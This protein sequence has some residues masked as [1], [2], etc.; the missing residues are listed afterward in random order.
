M[1][2]LQDDVWKRRGVSLLWGGQSAFSV[3]TAAERG[4]DSP[5]LRPGREV[6]RRTTLQ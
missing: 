3:G 5:I 4:Y 6:A 2:I 1:K